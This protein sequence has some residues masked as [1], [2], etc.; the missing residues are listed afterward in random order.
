MEP[1][2][3]QATWGKSN[4]VL[5]GSRGTLAWKKKRQK[6]VTSPHQHYHSLTNFPKVQHT[7]FGCFQKYLL[8][9]VCSIILT[10]G[11]IGWHIIFLG[12]IRESCNSVGLLLSLYRHWWRRIKLWSVVVQSRNNTKAVGK[13]KFWSEALW[14]K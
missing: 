3:A 5:P 7:I 6:A 8:A 2:T 1:D 11:P 12:D 10:T 9:A 13:N 4:P 14:Q